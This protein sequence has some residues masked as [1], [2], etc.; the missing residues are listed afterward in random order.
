MNAGGDLFVEAAAPPVEVAA[1]R[2]ARVPMIVVPTLGTAMAVCPALRAGVVGLVQLIAGGMAPLVVPL[3]DLGRQSRDGQS[4]A[5]R[6]STRFQV[7][8][9]VNLT[10]E[11]PGYALLSRFPDPHRTKWV[12][13]RN[14]FAF[15]GY[16]TALRVAFSF[17][18]L[19][20]VLSLEE[21]Y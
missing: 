12:M 1:S 21:E 20:A 16:V 17:T 15:R 19:P 5:M 13:R 6:T 18:W 2:T 11:A 7:A 10:I 3:W 9:V 8:G 14:V 4:R